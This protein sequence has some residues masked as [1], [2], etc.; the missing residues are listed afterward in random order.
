MFG[1]EIGM[2][3]LEAAGC[4]WISYQDTLS[5]NTFCDALPWY[6]I[7]KYPSVDFDAKCLMKDPVTKQWFIFLLI[8][9]ISPKIL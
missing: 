2:A 6:I 1:L 7:K 3:T 5:T 8:C 9:H 4:N